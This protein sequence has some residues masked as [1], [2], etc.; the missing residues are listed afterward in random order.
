M[1]AKRRNENGTPMRT[2]GLSLTLSIGLVEQLDEYKAANP[3][4]YQSRSDLIEKICSNYLDGET[5][6]R[7]G[8]QIPKGS[9]FC[10]NCGRSPSLTRE[11]KSVAKMIFLESHPEYRDND[12]TVYTIILSDADCMDILN[13]KTI[14]TPRIRTTSRREFEEQRQRIRE[15]VRALRE[16]REKMKL[17]VAG[18]SGDEIN[19]DN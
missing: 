11:E 13:G 12:E 16:E 14:P 19:K 9:L 6:P 1:A 4:K 10:S 2:M 8:T 5:C 17:D 18:K 3:D 7:C 15:R